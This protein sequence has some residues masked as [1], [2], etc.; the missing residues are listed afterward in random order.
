MSEEPQYFYKEEYILTTVL[1]SV[2]S[3][4]WWSQL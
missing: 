4:C 2:K 3:T 1:I